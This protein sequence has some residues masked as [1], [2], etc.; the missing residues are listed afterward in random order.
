VSLPLLVEYYNQLPERR[1]SDDA[2][3]WQIRLQA[4]TE[5]FKERVATR[6][7]EGTLLRLL[8]ASPPRIRRA[9]VLALGLVGS[10]ESNAA[11]ADRLHDS[12]N[13][14][15][16]L[17][18]DALWAIWFRADSEPNNL[19][20]QRLARLRDREKALAG[21]NQLVLN[22]PA[23]AEAY[24]QRAIVYFKLKQYDRSVADCDRAFDLNA[25]HFGALAGLGQC[26]MHLRKHKAALRAF[27]AALKIHPRLDGVA[28]T[29]RAL[30]SALG[31]E[32]QG[33]RDDKK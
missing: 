31:E 25:H 7:N 33:R 28:A 8:E 16:K 10:M 2:K 29:I 12:D 32:G 30:E 15:W 27:R 26:N 21:L 5:S 23:F 6:Y 14:V 13:Q 18:A 19:E 24:N 1:S 11:V 3:E 20:L 4:A 9:A 22:A 17:A